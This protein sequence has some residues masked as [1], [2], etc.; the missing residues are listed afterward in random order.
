MPLEFTPLQRVQL[1]AR[2]VHALGIGRFVQASQHGGQ[3]WGMGGLN[4]GHVP[5]L[6][7]GF[8]ALVPECLDHGALYLVALHGAKHYGRNAARD[9]DGHFSG[10]DEFR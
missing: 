5:F 2:Q 7:K 1:P 4:P 6:K 10:M 3:S 9:F 8:Q